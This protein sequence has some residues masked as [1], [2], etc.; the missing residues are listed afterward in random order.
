M[1]LQHFLGGL[2][3]LEPVQLETRV[4]VA[5]WEQRIFGIHTAM[6]ALSSHLKMEP[7]PSKFRD[8]WTWADLR[9]G[10]ESMN[11][12]DYFKFRYYEKWL[13]GIC[14]F[15][16]A[17]GYVTQE[18][19]E[20][21][22]K[23]FSKKPDLGYRPGGDASIDERVITYLRDGDSPLRETTLK[24]RFKEGETVVVRNVPTTEHTRLPGYLRNHRG[25]IHTVYPGTYVYLCSTGPDG[26]GPAMPV[27][28]VWFDPSELWG[29][30]GESNS[31]IY[32]DLYE[33]YLDKAD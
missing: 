15:F 24:P 16:V 5:P 22:T 4:F 9:K 31:V 1:K 20:A 30:A 11:P 19:L 28:C 10:A 14:G 12:L 17:K 33:A 3:G 18:E 32:A 25:V 29:D 6:M 26:I 21:R 7:T 27:Y 23:E 2:E 13:N 8:I